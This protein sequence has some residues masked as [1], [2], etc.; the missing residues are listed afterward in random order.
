MNTDFN[1]GVLCFVLSPTDVAGAEGQEASLNSCQA[2]K[3]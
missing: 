1:L 3:P 2:C